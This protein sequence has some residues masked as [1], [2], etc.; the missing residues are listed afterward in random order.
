MLLHD[1]DTVNASYGMLHGFRALFF[2]TQ[3]TKNNLFPL[4]RHT[5]VQQHLKGESDRADI[6]YRLSVGKSSVESVA[7]EQQICMFGIVGDEFLLCD[8]IKIAGLISVLA[9]R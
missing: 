3:K 6:Y 2:R 4:L 9:C 5:A 1:R 8:R 7:Q